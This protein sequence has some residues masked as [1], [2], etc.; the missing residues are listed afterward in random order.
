MGPRS[1]ALAASGHPHIAYGQDHLYYYARH[2][3][4]AW[5]LETVD[6]SWGVGRYTSLALD[7]FGRPHIGYFD[8]TNY[9]LK[10]ARFDGAAW[11]VET[12]DGAGYVGYDNSLALDAVGRPHIGYSDETNGDLKY[13]HVCAPV[14]GVQVVGTTALGVNQ[15]GTYRAEA[16][17]F[18]GPPITYTWDNGTLGPTA[19]YSWP[20]TGTY[21]ITVT[22]TNPCGTGR[23]ELQVRVLSEW[24]YSVYLPL[25][26]RSP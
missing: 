26:L 12:V 9:A 13:A 18:S 1:L 20:A 22:A 8:W 3:G 19:A 25:V 11:Q 10:Y 2:D 21:A 6:E 23:G 5:H 4:S 24:P 15:A 14:T 7:T 17:P 16:E